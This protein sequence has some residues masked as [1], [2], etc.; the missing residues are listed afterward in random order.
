MSPETLQ[1]ARGIATEVRRAVL[2]Q[3]DG[4]PGGCCHDAAFALGLAL[5]R[6]GFRCVLVVGGI[7]HGRSSPAN[8]W[9]VRLQ[10][11]PEG[12]LPACWVADVT[13]DQF[14][15]TAEACE[16]RPIPEVLIAPLHEWPVFTES[17]S[18]PVNFRRILAMLP[19][20]DVA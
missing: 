3:N 20:G 5:T 13:G 2:A 16:A 11:T 19:A 4:K 17:G 14:N 15:R 9:W 12:S 8:H 7:Q 1:R 18:T 6:A 10:A